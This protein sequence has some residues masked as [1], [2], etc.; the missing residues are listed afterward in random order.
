MAS[1]MIPRV[2]PR[3]RPRKHQP[4][5]EIEGRRMGLTLEGF[6]QGDADMLR[7]LRGRQFLNRPPIMTRDAMRSLV[8]EKQNL[9]AIGNGD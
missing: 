7:G 8:V 2:A 9:S 5:R 6:G 3:H 4:G 1:A